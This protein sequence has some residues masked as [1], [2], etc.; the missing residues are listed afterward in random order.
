MRI[1]IYKS[2]SGIRGI[3][4]LSLIY[5][6]LFTVVSCGM[7]DQ[8]TGQ[9]LETLTPLYTEDDVPKATPV[10]DTAI[11]NATVTAMP[12]AMETAQA[13]ILAAN[14]PVGARPEEVILLAEMKIN[15]LEPKLEPQVRHSIEEKIR[16]LEE[17]IMIRATGQAYEATYGIPTSVGTIA[18]PADAP[19][20]EG[21]PRPTQIGLMEARGLPWMDIRAWFEPT[22]MVWRGEQHGEWLQ[23]QAGS[24]SSEQ[25][26]IIANVFDAQGQQSTWIQEEA[27]GILVIWHENSTQL[28]DIYQ[29][30]IKAGKLTIISEEQG[31]LTLQSADGQTVRFDIAGRRFV[32]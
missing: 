16:F 24:A 23:I 9:E 13:A 4:L 31:I 21:T 19:L 7:P 27:Q 20:V 5:T 26:R 18:I 29:A 14:T 25:L 1:P 11:P 12:A 17:D 8:K 2:Y 22:Y 6:I 30:P 3:L 15:L 32:P 10:L 28:M